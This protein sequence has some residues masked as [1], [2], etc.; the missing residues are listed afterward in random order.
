MFK[1]YE[2]SRVLAPFIKQYWALDIDKKENTPQKQTI[3]PNGLMEIMFHYGDV[4]DYILPNK[5]AS[6]KSQC[7]LCGQKSIFYDIYTTGKIGIFSAILKPEGA[8]MFFDIPISEIY[9]ET[10]SI[11]EIFTKDGETLQDKIIDSKTNEE[12]ISI[13]ESFLSKK[14]IE[15]KL[16]DHRRMAACLDKIKAG[17]VKASVKDLA[18]CACLSTKQFQRRF[19]EHIGILPKEYLRVVRFQNAIHKK[20][21]DPEL[22]LTKLSYDCGY[23]DQSHF[24]RD[25][26]MFSGMTPKDFFQLS[27]TYSDFFD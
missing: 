11:Q 24:I 14:I 25:F 7:I 17:T 13:F 12:R 8:M 21:L 5:T 4:V 26:K 6:I 9:N 2:P 16:Y 27:E 10:V 20:H 15:K 19:N 1:F 22:S 3:I 23:Y 18:E